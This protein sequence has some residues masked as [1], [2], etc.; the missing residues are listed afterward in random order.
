M[1]IQNRRGSYLNFDPQKMKPGEFAIVQTNDPFATDGEAV[2]IAFQAGK[3]KRLATYDDTRSE[4]YDIVDEFINDANAEALKSEGYALGTQNTEEVPSSSTYYHNNSKYYAEQAEAS[5][6]QAE[7]SAEAAQV[8]ISFTDSGNGNI[9][10]T[11]TVG[12]N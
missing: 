9:I 2:Y 12:G 10:I 6:E 7:A 8:A 1:A 5:A 11:K 3:V 4:L